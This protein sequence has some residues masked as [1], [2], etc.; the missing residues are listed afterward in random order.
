M[1]R[2][3]IDSVIHFIVYEG[4]KIEKG[5]LLLLFICAIC[6]P[7]VG[8]NYDLSKYLPDFAPSKQALDVMEDEFGYPGM[9]RIM[10]KDVSLYE[11]KNI[12]DYISKVDGVDMVMG[13]DSAADI[14]MAQP[15]VMETDDLDDFYKDGNALIDIVF[16]DGDSDKTTHK[17]LDKIYE[18]VGDKGYFAGTAVSNKS[19]QETIVKEIAMAMTIAIIIIFAILTITTTSWF[20]PVLFIVVMGVAIVIN[21]GSN[22]IFGSISFFTFAT[23]AILQ[24]AVSMDYSIFLLHMFTANKEAGMEIHTALEK[25]IKDSSSSILASGATTIVGFLAIALMKFTVG[26]DV[27]FVLTKGIVVSLATVLLLMPTLILR[28]NARIEKY[29]HRS[30]MPSF[31]NLGNR[32]YK[33]R[34]III[35]LSLF[36]TIPTYV[37]QGMN[38]FLYGDDA[39]GA[40]PGTQVYEDSK[41]IDSV[42]GRSNMVIG[43]VPNGSTV[44]EKKLTDDIEEFEFINYAKSLSGELPVGIPQDFLPGSIVDKMR[45]DKYARIL[46]SMDTVQ[47]SDF[48]FEC[49]QKLEDKIREYYPENSY[50]VGMTPTTIDIKNILTKDYSFVSILSMI[51]VAIVVAL[52]FKSALVP[53][54]VIIPIEVAI[55]LNMSIPYIIGDTMLYIGYII[56]SCLQL[57]ATIDYSILLTNHYI[58]ARNSLDP[59]HSAK[60]AIS[61]SALSVLTSG[62][63][64]TV[65]GY[66]LFFSSTI[67]GIS[68]IGRLVGRGALFSMVLVLS[69]LPALLAMFDGPIERQ[70]KKSTERRAKMRLKRESKKNIKLEGDLDEII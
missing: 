22:I 45:T 18:I 52:T 64:L 26:K 47:E 43:I 48:A 9:A 46:I 44:L 1:K 41:V 51:G 14:Y 8:V 20:E 42:F 21:M 35:V 65:V 37:A 2:I 70:Q 55:Y 15:F 30:F 7:F 53:V 36:V 29:A 34:K 16:E 31:D 39:L 12:R 27:G 68:Q 61:R 33:I 60:A 5:F 54:V 58:E 28:Y 50:I 69:L 40:G 67:Q 59:E 19:R 57:G 38:N 17:A 66:G 62:S 25:A 32:M 11:A 6:Y 49:S 4:K 24:L 3:G 23:A 13:V 56:V 63:I 10:L